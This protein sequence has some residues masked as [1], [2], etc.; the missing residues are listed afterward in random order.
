MYNRSQLFAGLVAGL[1]TPLIVMLLIYEIRL[2]GTPFEEFVEIS[3][4]EGVI[5]KLIALSVIGNL[6]LFGIFIYTNKLWAARGVMISTL[7]Y[8]IVMLYFKLL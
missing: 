3:I 6:A 7:L 5:T 2:S 1:F 4:R 8:G